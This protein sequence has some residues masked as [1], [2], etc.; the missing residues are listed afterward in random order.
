M[1]L[2]K[3][4]GNVSKTVLTNTAHMNMHTEIDARITAV[5]PRE[6]QTR[7]PHP[8]LPAGDRHGRYLRQPHHEEYRNSQ[9]G[10]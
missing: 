10:G 3:Q 1:A 4:I 6:A 7:N 9:D 8:A 2:T 5:T